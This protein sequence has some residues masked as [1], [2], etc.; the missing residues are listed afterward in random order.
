MGEGLNPSSLGCVSATDYDQWHY[1]LT[2]K[3]RDIKSTIQYQLYNINYTI[4]FFFQPIYSLKS[5]IFLFSRNEKWWYDNIIFHRTWLLAFGVKDKKT[6]KI[7]LKEIIV[8]ISFFIFFKVYLN[9]INILDVCE[10]CLILLFRY[11]II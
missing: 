6:A 3:H 5:T 11:I 9:F 2:T 1:F 10:W 7:D 8:I 4:S